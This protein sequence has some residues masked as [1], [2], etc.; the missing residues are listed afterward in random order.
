MRQRRVPIVPPRGAVAHVAAVLR[1]NVGELLLVAG[2][3]L[4]MQGFSH[5]WSPGVYLVPGAVLVW[6]GL[7]SRLPFVIQ[8]PV[9]PR[10]G[11]EK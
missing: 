5:W 10:A 8:Q 4:L 3:L 2:T 6:I 7:P 9:P 11:E 1:E